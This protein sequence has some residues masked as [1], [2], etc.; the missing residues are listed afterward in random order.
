MND[1]AACIPD[2][3]RVAAAL[4]GLPGASVI[5]LYFAGCSQSALPADGG[6]CAPAPSDGCPCDPGAPIDAA[7]PPLDAPPG[8]CWGRISSSLGEHF[9][10]GCHFEGVSFRTK[11]YG[12]PSFSVLV[13]PRID[14]AGV[15]NSCE[16]A[17]QAGGSVLVYLPSGGYSIDPF[18]GP[19]QLNFQLSSVDGGAWHGTFDAIVP[20]EGPIAD[21]M[22]HPGANAMLHVDF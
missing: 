4:R 20:Y 10:L 9:E 3:Q 6:T 8:G 7:P 16:L 11:D 5:A 17:P 1:R 22:V 18:R 12:V 14:E 19:R 15:Y 13:I 2:F 21:M